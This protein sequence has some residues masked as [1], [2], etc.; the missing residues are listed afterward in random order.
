ML[1]PQTPFSAGKIRPGAAA[2]PFSIRLT[3]AERRSLLERAGKLPLGTFI[4]DLIL[5]D[6]LQVPRRR[7]VNPV[8]DHEALARVLAV[9]GQSRITNNLNQL[10]KAVNIGV[11]PVTA[12]TE[13]EITEA[14]ASVVS[15]RRDLMRALGLPEGGQP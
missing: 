12:E 8:K 3:E 1:P 15:M 2:R 5:G 11:L 6:G 13:R 14:C 4:R 9:L 10:A 7:V